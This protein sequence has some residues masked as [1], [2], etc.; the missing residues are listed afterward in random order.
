MNVSNS[1]TFP[2][3][4][5]RRLIP[6]SPIGWGAGAAAIPP[7]GLGPPPAGGFGP[8]PAGGFGG[9]GG[10]APPPLPPPLPPCCGW[11]VVWLV[12]VIVPDMSASGFE[13]W[14]ALSLSDCFSDPSSD[15]GS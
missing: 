10:G 11:V 8:P 6:I 2:S 3:N 14:S 5:C 13:F 15:S 4:G 1:S 7:G 9:G 12:T